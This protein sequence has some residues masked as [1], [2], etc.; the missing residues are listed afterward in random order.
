MHAYPYTMLYSQIYSFSLTVE[1]VYHSK[2][3]K[4]TPVRFKL[5]VKYMCGVCDD[6]TSNTP[7]KT[8]LGKI[9]RPDIGSDLRVVFCYQIVALLALNSIFL[10]L[11]T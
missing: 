10:A 3:Y 2:I 1:L 4:L 7:S 8:S 11:I 6:N 5:V 9:V